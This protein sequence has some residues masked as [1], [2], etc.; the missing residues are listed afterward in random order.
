MT[1]KGVPTAEVVCRSRQT[2][3]PRRR[4]NS[5]S[6]NS[7]NSRCSISSEVASS[8]GRLFRSRVTRSCD[9]ARLKSSSMYRHPRTSAA[10]LP[11]KP[12]NDPRNGTPA[13]R[14]AWS[15]RS[16]ARTPAGSLPCM[17]PMPTTSGPS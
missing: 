8:D 6:R 16:R 12:T 5:T 1:T 2:T 11:A 15:I 14:N 13:E 3:G 10:R 7:S 17:P 9:H 4:A